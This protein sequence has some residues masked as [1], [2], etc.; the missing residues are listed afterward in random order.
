MGQVIEITPAQRATRRA[1]IDIYGELDRKLELVEP[2]REQHKLL[3]KEI[4]SWYKNEDGAMP[5]VANGNDYRI[6][7]SA[8][9]NER[10]ITD[11]KKAVAALKRALGSLDAVIAVLDIPLGLIDKHVPESEQATFIHE[12]HSGYRTLE[13]VALHPPAGIRKAA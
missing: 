9:R 4:Q 12:E 1:K 6:Q 11:K 10:V 7:L 2:E 8:R 3:G 5:Q 13:A